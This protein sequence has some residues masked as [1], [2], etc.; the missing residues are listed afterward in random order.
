MGLNQKGYFL[1]YTLFLFIFVI[2]IFTF[3]VLCSLNANKTFNDKDKYYHI[4]ILE[5]RAKRHIQERITENNLVNN[6]KELVYYDEDF[7]Y[8]T[9]QLDTDI[10]FVSVRIHY[11]DINQY[12]VI[13]YHLDTNEMIYKLT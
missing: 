11:E 7:I 10:W 2:N 3:V 13:E 4:F 6:E 5:E 12:A 8:F 9:Y 1:P